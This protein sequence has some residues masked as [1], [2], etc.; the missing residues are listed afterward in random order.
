MQTH[1][2]KKQ[3][4]WYTDEFE[5]RIT[6]CVW[7]T[8]VHIHIYDEILQ[9]ESWNIWIYSKLQFPTQQCVSPNTLQSHENQPSQ[10]KKLCIGFICCWLHIQPQRC[11]PIGFRGLCLSHLSTYRLC[12]AFLPLSLHLGLIETQQDGHGTARALF[13]WSFLWGF[14]CTL[15]FGLSARARAT[16]FC[17]YG[18]CMMW[19]LSHGSV[20][21]CNFCEAG[22]K[23][24]RKCCR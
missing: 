17:E 7:C 12:V 20:H 2:T 23:C 24:R 11:D 21:T 9:Y 13:F 16:W 3:M 10:A 5:C 22:T 6:I 14:T 15:A 1:P 8:Y 18:C 19:L 4:I